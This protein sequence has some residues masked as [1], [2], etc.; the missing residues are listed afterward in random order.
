MAYKLGNRAMESDSVLVVALDGLDKDLIEEFELENVKQSE[1]GGIDNKTGI[2]SISTSELFASFITG[3]THQKHGIKGLNYQKGIKQK[4]RSFLFPE[5]L[6][7][8][9]RGTTRLKNAF[10]ALF[11]TEDIR[12]NKSHL[13]SES[14]FDQ[15]ENS[16]GDFIPSWNPSPYW[17]AL[18]FPELRSYDVDPKPL[19][20]YWDS[21]EY[22]VRKNKLFR[23]VNKWFDF[24]MIHFHRPDA[25]QHFYGDKELSTFDKDKL[26]ALYNE[27]DELVGKIQEFF[28]DDYE[29]II[30]MSDHGLPEEDEHNEKAFYSSNKAL[31]P[32]K[33]PHIT[34]FKSKI[35]DLNTDR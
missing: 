18:K 26:N 23:P 28:Q 15:I 21:Y 27:I 22:Q 30:F 2:S 29:Y 32:E 20:Y 14:I 7:K 33:E 4:L 31:F 9:V 17:Q 8:N 24:Y 12:P 1:F 11:D 25:H 13:E 6:L 5:V 35:L 34:S 19:E 3:E 16:K 10:N